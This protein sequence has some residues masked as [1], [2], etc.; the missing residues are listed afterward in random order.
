MLFGG[1]VL[2]QSVFSWL[3]FFLIVLSCLGFRG[4][5]KLGCVKLFYMF[6]VLRF[7]F[8]EVVYMWC[9]FDLTLF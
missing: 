3:R 5:I 8:N 2:F 4:L 6:M 9:W 7:R 1:S